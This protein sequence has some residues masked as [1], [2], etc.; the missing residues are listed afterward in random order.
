M[1]GEKGKVHPSTDLSTRLRWVVNVMP[2][3]L[4]PWGRDLVPIVQVA[5]DT[6]LQSGQVRMVVYHNNINY[7]THT[8][9]H[10]I[11]SKG[12]RYL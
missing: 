6:Q 8:Y 9:V 7:I 2:Q 1:L 5:G 4:Y 10:K 12:T 3:L 11:I